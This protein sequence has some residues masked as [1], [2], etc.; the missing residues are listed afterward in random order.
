MQ[1]QITALG[2]NHNKKLSTTSFLILMLLS[3]LFPQKCW[4]LFNLNSLFICC[5]VCIFSSSYR[6]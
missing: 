4:K 5:F 6:I 3:P 2:L 1:K